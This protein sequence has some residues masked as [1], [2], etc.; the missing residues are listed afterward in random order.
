MPQLT[1]IQLDDGTL[2]YIEASENITIPL[3]PESEHPNQEP[4]ETT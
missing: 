3:V 1:P 4:E 2:I